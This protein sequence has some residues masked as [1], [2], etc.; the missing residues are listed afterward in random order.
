MLSVKLAKELLPDGIKVN[1]VD[2]ELTATDIN[3]HMG[4]RTVDEGAKVAIEL[5]TIGAMGPTGGFFHDGTT[6]HLPR[7][8]W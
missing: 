2:P 7:H 1:V 4:D 5:A 8:H 3:G 6:R